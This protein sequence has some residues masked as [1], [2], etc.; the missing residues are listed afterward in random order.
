MPGGTAAAPPTQL[1]AGVPEPACR[2]DNV[3]IVNRASQCSH[4]EYRSGWSLLAR[5]SHQ[6]P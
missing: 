6:I 2:G 4:P 3:P 5:M 1:P